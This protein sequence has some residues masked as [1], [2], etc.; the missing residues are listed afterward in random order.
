MIERFRE[1]DAQAADL[2]RARRAPLAGL[3]ALIDAKLKAARPLNY[4]RVDLFSALAEEFESLRLRHFLNLRQ[5]ERRLVEA[6]GAV[7]DAKAVPLLE[8]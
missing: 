2:R 1:P 5:S 3:A 8:A 4:R 7:K 6:L